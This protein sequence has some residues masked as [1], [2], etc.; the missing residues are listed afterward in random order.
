MLRNG[1]E[2]TKIVA[3]K[4]NEKEI[5]FRVEHLHVD[6]TEENKFRLKEVELS[7][8][9]ELRKEAAR[10]VMH[11]FENYELSNEQILNY[12]NLST[13]EEL[14]DK[15][16]AGEV[17]L[18]TVK[19]NLLQNLKDERSKELVEADE[20]FLNEKVGYVKNV[21]EEIQL[22]FHDYENFTK[23]VE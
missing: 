19:R 12:L 14:E 8:R 1:I 10:K 17:Q 23:T 22:R 11:E 21:L 6:S 13:I 9:S 15:V 16:N 2:K 7:V 4:A 5:T 20:M 3:L 18:E